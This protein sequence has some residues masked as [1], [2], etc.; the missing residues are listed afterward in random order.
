ML[1]WITN[2]IM[3]RAAMESKYWITIRHYSDKY[4]AC[5]TSA[6][7]KDYMLGTPQK[8]IGDAK[9]SANKL[10]GITGLVVKF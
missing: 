9:R 8:R 3:E 4:M 10:S 5:I 7:G 2:D 1:Y 6:N